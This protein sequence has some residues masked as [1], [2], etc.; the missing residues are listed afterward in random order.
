[1]PTP[2]LTQLFTPLTADQVF[3]SELDIA[4]QVQL[5]VT[6]WQDLSCGREI[7]FVTAQLASNFTVGAFGGAAAGGLLDF[8]TGDWLT[9]LAIS[10][11]GV[12]RIPATFGAGVEE[13]TNVAAVDYDFA[14]GELVLVNSVTGAT[15]T[16]A[17]DVHLPA[18]SVGSPTVTPG[19]IVAQIAGTV[20]SANAGQVTSLQ[21]PVL[22]VS[23]TNTTAIA[24]VDEQSDPSLRTLCRLSM[25][26]ASPNGPVDA[27]SYFATTS[28]R[29]VDGASVGVTRTNV[30][31]QN[32]TVLVYVA[33]ASGG[34]PGDAS[35]PN[36][37]IGAVN[38]NI[39]NNCVPTGITASTVSATPFPQTITAQVWRARGSTISDSA[40]QQAIA[41]QLSSYVKSVPI[42]GFN[43]GTG[44]TL[45]LDA[46]IG[47]IFQAAPGQV[48][49]VTVSAPAGDVAVN[50][51]QVVTIGPGPVNITVNQAP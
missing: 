30:I 5:P 50:S 1:M 34:V 22:G 2:T 17:D 3:A 42:G 32:G 27:Y 16:N 46:I 10:N 25:A 23:V 45:F 9:L 35:D 43:I 29:A 37:D 36:T 31:Q 47:Q 15:Y 21:S 12:T 19:V 7:L 26:R 39:Q 18:G 13:Y 41:N 38:A 44:G 6:A 51:N 20:G 24:G 28:V 14:A 48:V 49:Q 8:A 11:F 4:A 40:L 33:S